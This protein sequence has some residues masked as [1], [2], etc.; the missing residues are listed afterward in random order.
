LFR[1]DI[2]I[3]MKMEFVIDILLRTSII[4]IYL[5]KLLIVNE[6]SV[7]TGSAWQQWIVVVHSG[8]A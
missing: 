6:A 1:N 8:S 5:E 3:L 2:K 7:H 4:G